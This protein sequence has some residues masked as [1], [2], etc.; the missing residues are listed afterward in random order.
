MESVVKNRSCLGLLKKFTMMFKPL[1]YESDDII[2]LIEL[3]KWKNRQNGTCEDYLTKAVKCDLIDIFRAK[4]CMHDGE[5]RVMRPLKVKYDN[6]I[7]HENQENDLV[8]S[9]YQ[10]NLGYVDPE[11][12]QVDVKDTLKFFLKR[13][14]ETQRKVL[15]EYFVNGKNMKTVGKEVGISESRVSQI[16]KTCKEIASQSVYPF[17]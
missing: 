15:V 14:N 3:L 11:F 13:F 6:E 2:Q 8:S 1:G 4:A 17:P 9:L 7:K 12:E 5:K 10:A 16:V